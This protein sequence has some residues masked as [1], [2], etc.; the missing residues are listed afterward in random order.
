MPGGENL[1]LMPEPLALMGQVG[2]QPPQQMSPAHSDLMVD[3]ANKRRALEKACSELAAVRAEA[4]VG[5]KL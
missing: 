2:V 4:A 1:G 5:A 3:M